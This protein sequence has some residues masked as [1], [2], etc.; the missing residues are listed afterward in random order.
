MKKINIFKI[1]LLVIC[2]AIAV[3]GIY[4]CIRHG[5]GVMQ[6]AEDYKKYG[7]DFYSTY[8]YL[9]QIIYLVYILL[10]TILSIF[11][12]IFI[13]L[14]I[15]YFKG[16]EYEDYKKEK[17]ERRKEKLKRKLKELE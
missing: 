7:T 14:D 1:T 16:R 10:S 3:F 9:N 5:I 6:L 4:M 12:S 8:E 2:I 15:F 17:N 11:F 13:S